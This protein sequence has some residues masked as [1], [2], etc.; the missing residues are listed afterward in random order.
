M[1]MPGTEPMTLDATL[2]QAV[3]HHQAE[4]FAEAERLYRSILQAQPDHP[5]ANPHLGMLAVQLEQHAMGLP[6][7]KAALEASPQQAEFRRDY[8]DAL[9]ATGQRD[10][11][12]RV[13]DAGRAHSTPANAGFVTGIHANAATSTATNAAAPNAASATPTNVAPASGEID[14]LAVQF[15]ETIALLTAKGDHAS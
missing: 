9:E 12:A 3:Q 6:F 10:E 13:R 2:Q 8:V 11:A 5:E 1:P 15:V 7:L 14:A 4:A